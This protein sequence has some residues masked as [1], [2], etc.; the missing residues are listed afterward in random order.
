MECK[1]LVSIVV[2]NYNYV[3]YIRKALDS[4]VNQTY[5]NVEVVVV[6]DGST[7]GS[8]DTI[9][10]YAEK[11]DNLHFYKNPH[12]MGVVYTHNRCVE[13]SQ[14]E[15]LVVLSSDDYLHENFIAETLPV[16]EKYPSAAMIAADFW[17]VDGDGQISSPESFYP[18]SFFC[19]GIYQC[20]IWLFTNTFVPSQVLF[21]RKCIEDRDIGDRFSHQADTFV[22][23][24]LW[25]RM[26]LKYDFVYLK[27]K[28]CY[29]RMHTGSYSK[30]Y[31]SLKLYLQWY[32]TR[33]RFAAL[34]KDI[35]YLAQYGEEAVLRTTRIGTRYIR[36]LLEEGD[37]E[38]A[39]RYLHLTEGFDLNIKKHPY[40][41]FVCSCIER[42][43]LTQ[44][45]AA[46]LLEYE[47]DYND[48]CKSEEHRGKNIS[49][50]YDLPDCVEELEQ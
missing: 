32:L 31:E 4:A 14:G 24:E 25:Y 28:L 20:K 13:L 10:E 37:Y 26:C 30:S 48:S 17:H 35:P 22:D 12:N 1:P 44:Q 40:H 45:E 19:K 3:G 27:K 2:P 34:A 47:I 21:R 18:K 5:P 11:Y 36:T 16:L 43:S 50:P 29:Y 33:K 23:T 46:S 42:K 38:L 7:D 6:D 41:S 8:A 9:A 39:E 49:A 15:Y